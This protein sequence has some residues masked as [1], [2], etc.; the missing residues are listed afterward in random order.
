MKYEI[1]T[2]V[3]Y[4]HTFFP[5]HG[6]EGIRVHI[7]AAAARSLSQQGL[8][9]KRLRDGFVLLYA[10][11]HAGRPRSRDAVLEENNTL[12]FDLLLTDHLFY[13]YTQVNVQDI[14]SSIFF[15][16]NEA[17]VAAGTLH[18]QDYVSTQDLQAVNTLQETFFVKPFGRI[19][20]QVNGQLQPLYQIRFPARAVRWCYFLMSEGL[21]SLS[22]PAVIAANGNGYFGALRRVTLPDGREVPVFI[23][24]DPVPLG[25]AGN[26]FQLVDYFTASD[27]RYK[28]II[29]ALPAPE[30]GSISN[31]AAALYE[32]GSEYAEFFLY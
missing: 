30:T 18:R 27:D 5:G 17:P 8:L 32:N 31:A 10:A 20:L 11:V 4:R 21:Q 1:L 26:V 12:L 6:Y 22:R 14:T 23:S 15:F 2:E 9:V 28:V 16:S 19:A 3:V 25:S 13:N 24:N 7:P 29:P